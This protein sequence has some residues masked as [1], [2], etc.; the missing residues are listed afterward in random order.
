MPQ[1][2]ELALGVVVVSAAVTDLTRGL[3]HNWVT[4]PGI[5]LGLVLGGVNGGLPGLG[6]S[7]LGLLV[8]GGIMLLPY[9]LGAMG[10][11]DVKLLAA[12]GALGGPVFTFKTLIYS[13]LAGGVLALWALAWSGNLLAGLRGLLRTLL[14]A[15]TPGR[16]ATVEPLGLPPLPFGLCVLAGALCAAYGDFLRLALRA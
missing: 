1:T 3:I 15:V 7:A 14:A 16:K 2:W 9:L 8:G 4:L 6:W 5:L 10:G 13:C 12:V 11:G